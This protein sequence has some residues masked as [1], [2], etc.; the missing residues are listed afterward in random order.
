MD[1]KVK[2]ILRTFLYI[3]SDT[4]LWQDVVHFW[5]VFYSIC[6][7]KLRA[8]ICNFDMCPCVTRLTWHTFG[9]GLE[10]ANKNSNCIILYV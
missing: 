10:S 4:G 9:S 1:V 7:F 5:Y 2:I 3:V 8:K 6:I